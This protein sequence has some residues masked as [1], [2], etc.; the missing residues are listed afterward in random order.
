MADYIYETHG[1]HKEWTLKLLLASFLYVVNVIAQVFITNYFLGNEFTTYGPSVIEF[2]FSKSSN[3]T[4]PMSYVF[5]LVTKCIFEKY[6]PSGTMMNLDAVCFL[7]IN[8]S[9]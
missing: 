4:D 3:R 7:P 9:N 1:S 6:G 2:L 5:P 8:R